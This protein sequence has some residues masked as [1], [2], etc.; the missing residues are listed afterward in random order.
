M[1]TD[2]KLQRDTLDETIVRVLANIGS[3]GLSP[4]MRADVET[5]AI[6]AQKMLAWLRD[7]ARRA[8]ETRR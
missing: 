1:T 5:V 6:W 4:A 3:D 2:Q 7:Q 8:E